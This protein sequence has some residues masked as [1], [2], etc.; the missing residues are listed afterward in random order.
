MSNTV[1]IN[2][3][4]G[5]VISRP[6]TEQEIEYRAYLETQLVVPDPIVDPSEEIRASAL[7]KLMALGLTEEE[8][9]VIAGV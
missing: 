5:E 1:E 2:V 6:Y 9:R 4:T 7:S 8:A 3:N